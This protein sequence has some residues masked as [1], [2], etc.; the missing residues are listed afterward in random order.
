MYL[1]SS[2][3]SNALREALATRDD[4]GAM[5][6][7]TLGA[8][9]WALLERV[10]AFGCDNGCYSRGE[11]FD[12]DRYLAW[13]ST[14]TWAREKCLF[15]T[16]PD[17]MGNALATWERSREVLPRI[18]DLGLPAALVAQDGIERMTIE[19]DV[20]DVLF[21][22]GS[23]EFKLHPDRERLVSQAKARGKWVHMG[24]VNSLQR[25]RLAHDWG[26]DSADGNA[27]GFCPTQNLPKVLNWLDSLKRQPALW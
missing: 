27:I 4:L 19:W 9:K 11:E 20:F 16:G 26:C 8:Y 17:V 18:R 2:A 21:L 23:T 1:T 15:A 14:L 5:L 22:G 25:L 7:P 12:L 13:L 24:R 3:T 6:T 10:K